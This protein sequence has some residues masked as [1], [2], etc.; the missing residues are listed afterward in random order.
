M[1]CQTC[2]TKLRSTAHFC[3]HCGKPVHERFGSA[4]LAA[5]QQT[6]TNELKP[7][8]TA[9]QAADSA[10][11]TPELKPK[12]RTDQIAQR[13]TERQPPAKSTADESGAV[14]VAAVKMTEF[15]GTPPGAITNV[16][17]QQVLQQGEISAPEL[18]PRESFGVISY[19]VTQVEDV[20]LDETAPAIDLSTVELQRS[21]TGKPFFTQWLMPSAPGEPNQQHRRL[22]RAVPLVLLALLVLLVFAYLASK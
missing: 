9:E 16:S 10:P 12:Q 19:A 20:P 3:N 1:F 15:T 8:Q 11:T 4:Q 2:G 22:A 13:G 18:S 14:A 5:T 21:V 7:G 6:A 17:E